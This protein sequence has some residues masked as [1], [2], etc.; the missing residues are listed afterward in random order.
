[1]RQFIFNATQI[2]VIQQLVRKSFNKVNIWFK[3]QT[4]TNEFLHYFLHMNTHLEIK[5]NDV[6]VLYFSWI[7]D[8]G[9]D[10]D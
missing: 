6:M 10:F 7:L 1:M 9:F 8:I 5:L 4:C 2:I 3:Y